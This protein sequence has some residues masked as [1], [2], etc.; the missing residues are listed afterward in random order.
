MGAF[1]RLHN[2]LSWVTPYIHFWECY[3][4]LPLFLCFWASA[5]S[6]FFCFLSE[7]KADRYWWSGLFPIFLLGLGCDNWQR[8]YVLDRIPMVIDD[9]FKKFI[10]QAR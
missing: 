9:W 7:L 2:F 5:G 3:T 10:Q 6:L 1:E 8:I 4:L